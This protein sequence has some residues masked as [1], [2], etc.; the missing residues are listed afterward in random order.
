MFAFTPPISRGHAAARGLLA[1]VIGLVFVVLPGITIATAVVLFAVYCLADAITQIVRMFSSGE[2]VSDRIWQIV[3]TI[4]DVAAAAVAIAL[5][6]PTA[7]VLVIVIGIWAI[8][9]GFAELAMAFSGF[10]GGGWLGLTGLLSV[11]AGIVLIVWPGPGAFSLALVT[12]IYLAAYGIS[13]L[14]SAAV[15][16]S[17]ESVSA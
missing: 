14:I 4:I 11:A 7:A 13:L 17:G 15:A 16:P 1:L 6:A 3:V 10:P 12:G 9:G 8:V 2:S 5:P